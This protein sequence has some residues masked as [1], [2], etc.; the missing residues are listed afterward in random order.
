MIEAC[1]NLSCHQQ[2]ADLQYLKFHTLAHQQFQYYVKHMHGISTRYNTFTIKSLWYGS[3]QGLGDT[4]PRWVV[5]ADSLI[6]AYQTVA[7]TW[8]IHSPNHMQCIQQGFDAYVDDTDIIAATP[9]L[10]TTDPVPWVHHNLNYWHDIL[11]A[12]GGKLN[13]AKCVWLYFNWTF[14]LNGHPSILKSQ[15]HSRPQMTITLK[16]QALQVIR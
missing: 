5:Q 10:S 13:L 4:A 7:T 12:S 8:V 6:S 15:P 9:V 11:Q 2:G 16:N 14:N 1:Q 3:G